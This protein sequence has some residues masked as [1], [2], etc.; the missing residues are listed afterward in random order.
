M[1]IYDTAFEL[2]YHDA[3]EIDRVK[4]TRGM[5]DSII[6][7]KEIHFYVEDLQ[8]TGFVYNFQGK[9]YVIT[10]AAKDDYGLSKLNTLRIALGLGFALAIL[11]TLLAGV[12]FS[13]KVLSPVSAM[14]EKVEAIT[15]SHL[16]LRIGTGNGRDEMAEL[17]P[18]PLTGC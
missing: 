14:V 2:L 16:D 1:A 4:E 11:L 9:M 10:A 13:G 6:Q 18:T 5:I 7:L 12:L 17:A 8:A 3:M 15:A